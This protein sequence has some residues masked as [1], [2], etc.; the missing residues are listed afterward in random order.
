MST[1]DMSEMLPKLDKFDPL[2]MAE[3]FN[4]QPPQYDRDE[5]L[6]VATALASGDY[7]RATGGDTPFSD[8][9]L[10]AIELI[11]TVDVAVKGG[12]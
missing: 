10:D 2:A 12:N 11:Q 7:A 9:V 4:E 3:R 6:R 5:V 8:L 1:K